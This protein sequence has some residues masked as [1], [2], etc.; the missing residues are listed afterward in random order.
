MPSPAK[1][2]KTKGSIIFLTTG[3]LQ[4]DTLLNV[5]GQDFH[6]HSYLLKTHSAFFVKFLDSKDKESMSDKARGSSSFRYEWI[7]MA[8]DDK[9]GWHLIA[10]PDSFSENSDSLYKAYKGDADFEQKAFGSVSC[11]IYGQAYTFS[12]CLALKTLTSLA[13]YYKCLPILSR[14]ITDGLLNSP[15]MFL[16]LYEDACDMMMLAT[17][18]RNKFLFT[19]AL[20]CIAGNVELHS[21]VE[22]GNIP[23]GKIRKIGLNVQNAVMAKVVRMQQLLAEAV[24][25]LYEE[26]DE[27]DRLSLS[28]SN[29]KSASFPAYF[30]AILADGPWT[31]DFH[32]IDLDLE[33]ILSSNLRFDLRMRAGNGIYENTLLCARIDDDDLPVSHLFI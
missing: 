16:G 19:E 28:M 5:L 23:I 7:S 13:D 27:R 1:K 8:D 32:K 15:R 4:P 33:D 31:F 3:G 10:K 29:T 24:N 26:D 22:I 14:T 9:K 11:A 17:K 2:Q 18:I 30:R 6:V 12:S 21:N 25:D 20:I